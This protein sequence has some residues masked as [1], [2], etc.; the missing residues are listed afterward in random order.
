M[1][2]KGILKEID[3]LQEEQTAV[4]QPKGTLLD[5]FKGEFDNIEAVG[6]IDGKKVYTAD[7]YV[8]LTK[9]DA[10]RKKQGL[11]KSQVGLNA[12]VVPEFGR[13]GMLL[14]TP[15][16]RYQVNEA[17]AFANAVEVNSDNHTITLVRDFRAVQE[18]PS[19]LLYATG[20]VGYVIGKKG[21]NYAVLD[22]IIVPEKDF[23]SGYHAQLKGDD[24]KMM[25]EVI[26]H[27]EQSGS[28]TGLDLD[29][30]FG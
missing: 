4:A 10:E 22:K 23:I 9:M 20:V 13:D 28:D 19:G 2:T 15:R 12:V 7:N 24:I 27:Y 26:D 30:I 18:K 6:A 14:R 8:E 5:F 21:K 29:A 1:T 11:E 16:E 17:I 3:N 25:F